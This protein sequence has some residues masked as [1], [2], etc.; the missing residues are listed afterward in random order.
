MTE[1]T[2][3]L[4]RSTLETGTLS[5]LSHSVDQSKLQDQPRFKAQI[6]KLLSRKLQSYFAKDETTG[7]YIT[8]TIFAGNLSGF[9]WSVPTNWSI[10]YMAL[11]PFLFKSKSLAKVP[12]IFRK[13]QFSYTLTC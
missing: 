5:I 7:S 2:Q 10:I 6:N 3:G 13:T 11:I 4:L 8:E 1:S 12:F 9:L